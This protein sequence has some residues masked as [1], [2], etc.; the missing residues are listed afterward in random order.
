MTYG[1]LYP[2]LNYNVID[3]P[4]FAE[5]NKKLL[6]LNWIFELRYELHIK[7]LTEMWCPQ[8]CSEPSIY[9]LNWL[10]VFLRQLE[11]IQA[12]SIVWPNATNLYTPLPI[13]IQVTVKSSYAGAPRVATRKHCGFDER[14]QI[15]TQILTNYAFIK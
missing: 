3:W 11:Q 8:K 7:I 4:A 13:Q 5:L 6:T 1:T 14:M 2:L 15:D 9:V 10:E 12:L